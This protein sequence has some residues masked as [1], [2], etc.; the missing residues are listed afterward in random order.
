MMQLSKVQNHFNRYLQIGGFPEL[1]LADNDI[2]ARQIMRE[3]VG[4]KVL[5]RDLPSLYNHIRDELVLFCE[6]EVHAIRDDRAFA[7]FKVPFKNRGDSECHAIMVECW[8][9]RYGNDLTIDQLFLHFFLI[10]QIILHGW[11]SF[12]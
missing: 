12:L 9:G 10:C 6:V 7:A 2:M 1:D 5:K 4:D 8:P 11:C 3:D